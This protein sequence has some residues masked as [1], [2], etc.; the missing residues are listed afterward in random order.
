MLIVI[1]NPARYLYFLGERETHPIMKNNF[2]LSTIG[3]IS[4]GKK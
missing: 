4:N 1:R 3:Y 2:L